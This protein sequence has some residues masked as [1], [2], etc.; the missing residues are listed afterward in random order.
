MLTTWIKSAPHDALIVSF[1]TLRDFHISMFRTFLWQ[2]QS[3]RFSRFTESEIKFNQ[4]RFSNFWRPFR[5][6]SFNRVS[7]PSTRSRLS[8]IGNLRTAKIESEKSKSEKLCEGKELISFVS[9]NS[10]NHFTREKKSFEL[11]LYWWND[12]MAFPWL[13]S[14]IFSFP[15]L[16]ILRLLLSRRTSSLFHHITHRTLLFVV[17]FIY[18]HFPLT[19]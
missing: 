12:S 10:A 16:F 4:H 13:S 11:M 2:P 9:F 6:V 17:I 3:W 19:K 18:N 15:L 14:T 8:L 7:L 5:I 1:L